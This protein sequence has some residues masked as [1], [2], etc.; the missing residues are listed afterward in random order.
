MPFVG[1]DGDP[2]MAGCEI[3]HAASEHEREKQRQKK[4][5]KKATVKTLPLCPYSR[6]SARNILIRQVR[7]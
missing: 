2:A 4:I 1:R 6:R 5:A 3:A 7:Q